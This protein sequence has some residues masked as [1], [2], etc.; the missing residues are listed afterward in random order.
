[1]SAYLR[2]KG[3]SLPEP[4]AIVV[5]S[6]HWEE[7][8]DIKVTAASLPL[9]F[10]YGGFPA[11]TYEYSYPAPGDAQLAGATPSSPTRT[12]PKPH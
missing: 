5:I 7:T 9:L 10:D 6:A 3:K 1:L 11:E 8:K 4:S 2:G 12:L